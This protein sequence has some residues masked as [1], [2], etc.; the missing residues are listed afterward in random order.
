MFT[1]VVNNGARELVCM[2]EHECMFTISLHATEYSHSREVGTCQDIAG[3][4]PRGNDAFT[5]P[6]GREFYPFARL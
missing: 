4:E 3:A 6:G 1:G 5:A 2:S